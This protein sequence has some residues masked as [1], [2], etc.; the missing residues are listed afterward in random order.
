MRCPRCLNEDEYY[1]YQGS[2]GVYCRRCIQFKRQLIDDD[3]VVEHYEIKGHFE[4]SL[5]YEL[6]TQQLAI[7][8]QL[9]KAIQIQDVLLY[10]VCGA[11]KTELVIALIQDYLNRGKKVAYAI[12]RRQ[13]VIEL[14]KR[15][16]GIFKG[17]S[18]ISVCGGFTSVLSA[19]LIVLTTHQ[20][21]RYPQT[22]DLL[23]LDEPDAFPYANNEV[24]QS[25]ARNSV[26]GR[27]VYSTATLNEELKSIQKQC[28]TLHLNRRPHGFDLPMPTMIVG[29]K[30]VLLVHLLHFIKTHRKVII[31]TPTIHMANNYSK[32]FR[33]LFSV[34][35]IT[36]KTEEKQVIIDDFENGKIHVLF[37]TTILERGV[38]FSGVEVVVVEP[39]HIVYTI[40]SLIQMIGRVGRSMKNPKGDVLVLST[41]WSNKMKEVKRIIEEANQS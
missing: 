16:E 36:S 27:I 34:S 35:C 14:T 22:F 13:V 2:K 19:D 25:I 37:A 23:I 15:F 5:A 20:L 38:T 30:V 6:T 7:S 41:S 10:C 11:G 17:A 39:E 18:V 3:L 4:V 28:I 12:S 8:N 1:F 24:L 32:W 21:Y 29:L 9:L 26:N 31:F 40:A 33:H